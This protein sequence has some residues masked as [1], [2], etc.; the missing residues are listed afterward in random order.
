MEKESF[1]VPGNDW[2]M[3]AT[4]CSR[5]AGDR[6]RGWALGVFS[7]LELRLAKRAGPS[8]ADS[9]KMKTFT[10]ISFVLASTLSVAPAQEKKSDRSLGEKSAGTLEKAGE[11]T[12]EVGRAIGDTAKKAANSVVDAV[13]PDKDARKVEVTLTE[14]HID[15]PKQIES[16]RTAF[17][18]R[19]AGKEKHNF[20][21]TGEGIDKKFLATVDPNE[22]KVLH[23]DLKP[24]AYKI[25][26]PVKDHEEEGMKLNL[27]VK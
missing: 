20:E 27:T 11:K 16:G 2:I 17:V 9:G 14:H 4:V 8:G 15:M 3:A 25:I 1:I 7:A 12:K 6:F 26:C 10:I 22:T 5:D 24:G 18:V 19:N 23:V 13:T 21:L